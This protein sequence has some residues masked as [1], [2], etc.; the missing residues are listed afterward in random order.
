MLTCVPYTEALKSGWDEL[1]LAR[2]TI[3]HTTAFR[4]ILA[5]SFGYTPADHAI[6]DADGNIAALIPL[7]IGRNLRLRRAGVSLPFANHADLCATS[8]DARNAAFAALPDIAAAHRLAYLEVR[9]TEEDGRPAPAAPGW[10][11]N[12]ANYTFRLPLAG[13]EAQVL[14]L[15]TSGNR[16][17]IRKAVKHDLF[18]VSFDP[19][20]LEGFYRVYCKRM[21]ELGSPAP[22]IRFFESFFRLLPGHATLLT[23]LDRAGGAVVGGMLLLA[24]PG[25]NTLYYP[26]G[27]TL[28]EYNSRYLGNFMYWEAVKFA[29]ASGFGHLDLGRSPA[30]SGTYR[31]KEQWGARSVRLAYLTYSPSGV[32]AGPPDRGRLGPLVELWRAAPAFVTDVAGPRLI[33]YL[34]P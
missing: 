33:G 13:G 10:T 17:H 28:V 18:A 7:V 4:R 14:A 32:P 1:A 6:L 9:L 15:S 24:S 8:E 31:Y 19:G 25:D 27:A 23:V 11:A 29:I 30:G 26:Y 34:L 22:A 3:Y 21:K 16:N 5:D 20:N 2:G 12:R